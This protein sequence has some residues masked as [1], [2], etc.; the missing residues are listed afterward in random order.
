MRWSEVRAYLGGADAHDPL[1]SP[2]LSDMSGFPPVLLLS[3]TR[4]AVLSATTNFHRALRRA[5]ASAPTWWCSTRCRTHAWYALHLQETAEALGVMADFSPANWPPPLPDDRCRAEEQTV[6][7]T[8]PSVMRPIAEPQ[9]IEGAYSED[10][11]RR[12]LDVVRNNG[13][14]KLILAQHFNSAEEL[15]ATVSGGLPEGVEPTLDMFLSPVFRGYFSDFGVCLYP[16]SQD[17]FLNARFIELARNYWNADYAEPESMLFNLQGPCSGGGAPH[18]DATCFRGITS[19][20]APIWLM[21]TMSKSGLFKRWQAKKAQVIA[22]YYQG[23]I[24]GGFTYW[25]A[26]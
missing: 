13:P 7:K 14:F 21:N 12:M 26:A 6:D 15:I 5:G 25:R 9:V 10:Q 11:H 24:G 8:P 20:N 19:E 23:N 16:E 2:V 4:D 3:G 17:C 22:W 1:V 18:V